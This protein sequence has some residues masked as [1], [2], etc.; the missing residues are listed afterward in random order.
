MVWAVIVMELLKISSPF[1]RRLVLGPLEQPV[2][3][4]REPVLQQLY[5]QSTEYLLQSRMLREPMMRA[6]YKK[7]QLRNNAAHLRKR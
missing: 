5:H 4:Q 2:I 3:H 7:F 1:V 6:L